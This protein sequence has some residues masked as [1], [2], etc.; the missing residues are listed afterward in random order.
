MRM[1]DLIAAKRDGDTH[2]T[3]ELE[4]LIDGV[5][6][7]QVPDY[8]LAAWLMAV[9]WR[10]MSE[11]EATD[12]TRALI[13]SGQVLDM[14]SVAPFL[15]DKHSTGGVGDKTSLV[16]APL[17][18][19][20]GLPVVK[21]SGR[22]LGYT[23]GTLDKLES[24]PGFNVSLTV[25]ELTL[26]VRKH[27]IAIIG[28]TAEL[29][30]ADGKLYALRD[31]TATVPSLPLI[32]SS[33]M[34]KKIAS[35]A[36]AIVLDVK[37]GRGAFM[38]TVEQAKALAELMIRIGTGLG[39]QVTAVLADM[40]QPLGCAV[41]NALEVVEAVSTLQGHGPADFS[42]HCLVVASE[43]LMLGRLADTPDKARHILL[44]IISR[45]QAL[46]KFAEWIAAQQGDARIA[47]QPGLL[48]RAP[49]IA[50][51][52]AP[53]AGYVTGVDA[54][55]VGLV[56]GA[57]GAGRERKGQHVDPAVGLVMHVKIGQLVRQGEPLVQIHA[58]S[59]EAVR[60][61]K[62]RLADAIT[63]GAESVQPPPTIYAVIRG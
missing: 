40:N 59:Q 28:Q 44:D 32:A 14:H 16:V 36:D 51:L 25:Q 38:E 13:R 35:G 58:R 4:W 42:E 60:E 62:Q 48:P 2:S 53:V 31:V 30:P 9:L 37:V 18:A 45:G 57:L 47:E 24:I 33:I 27:G 3:K 46:D 55:E 5:Q 56:A 29:A 52:E 43:M 50:D 54:R 63:L 21:M 11:R 61:A 7:D 1:V 22:G 49:V 41:G 19:A 26:L 17:V 10:G 15:V 34:S 8:Q 39:K 23:G 20:A 12:L 6:R